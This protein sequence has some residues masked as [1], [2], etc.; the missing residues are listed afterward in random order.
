MYTVS[1]KF[2]VCG[3]Y[4]DKCRTYD[5]LLRRQSFFCMM[6]IFEL[7]K[8]PATFHFVN[9]SSHIWMRLNIQIIL[10]TIDD[11]VEWYK[12]N[13]FFHVVFVL[14]W[15]KHVCDKCGTIIFLWRVSEMCVQQ[16]VWF[17]CWFNHYVLLTA[18]MFYS[19]PRYKNCHL[20]NNEE[21][22]NML[23]FDKSIG[24][25]RIDVVVDQKLGTDRHSSLANAWIEE[26]D[27]TNLL[28]RY[29]AHSEK[30][31]LSSV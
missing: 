8:N 12:T 19:L 29:C 11:F 25:E 4:D 26:E 5:C 16:M 3:M 7:F 10:Y 22:Q 27:Q 6:W 14:L 24:V 2:V 21:L 9:K 20:D 30:V 17:V 31:L 13:R 15:G 28:R 18:P 23:L 1:L